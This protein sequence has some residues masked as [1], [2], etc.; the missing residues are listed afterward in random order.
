MTILIACVIWTPSTKLKCI[1]DE[2]DAFTTCHYL[3]TY[4]REDDINDDIYWNCNVRLAVYGSC[5]ILRLFVTIIG[6]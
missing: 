4:E 1:P 3:T 2:R 5:D 6:K